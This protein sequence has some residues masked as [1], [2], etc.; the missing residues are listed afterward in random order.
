MGLQMR[1]LQCGTHLC[2]IIITLSKQ[3]KKLIVPGNWSM[4]HPDLQINQNKVRHI[5]W[6]S[7]FIF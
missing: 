4:F 5:E 2:I 7:T 6:G 3:T 1:I